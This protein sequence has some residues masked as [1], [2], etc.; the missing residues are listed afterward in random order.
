MEELAIFEKG[1][2]FAS[3]ISFGC[4]VSRVGQGVITGYYHDSLLHGDLCWGPHTSMTHCE[5]AMEV[6]REVFQR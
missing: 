1:A 3:S 6:E 5:E 2:E 4:F